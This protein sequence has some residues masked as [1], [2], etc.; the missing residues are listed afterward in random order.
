MGSAIAANIPIISTTTNNSIRVK[1]FFIINL[2][3]YDVLIEGTYP[4]L[5][6]YIIARK[7]KNR[8]SKIYLKRPSKTINNKFDKM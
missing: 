5:H 3:L 7:K 1:P 8:S 4:P 6:T 2:L